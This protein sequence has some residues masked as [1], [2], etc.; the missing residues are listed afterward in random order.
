MSDPPRGAEALL[1]SVR[2]RERQSGFD[3]VLT[4]LQEA[5]CRT[6]ADLR[7][8]LDSRSSQPQ[9]VK[10]AREASRNALDR[11]AAELTSRSLPVPRKI[12]TELE[13]LRH[14]CGPSRQ[15]YS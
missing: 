10:A 6:R 11:Y 9:L 4:S 8:V 14:L 7:E 12:H 15:T 5:V 1:E 2:P 3:P 13:L